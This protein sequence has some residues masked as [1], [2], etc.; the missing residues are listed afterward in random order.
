M[1]SSWAVEPF[2]SR[3][4]KNPVDEFIM[5]LSPGEQ[6]KIIYTIQLLE[7]LGINLRMPHSRAI[8]GEDSL[9]EL[10]SQYGSNI[11]RIFYFHYTGKTFILLHGFTK[12]TQKTPIKEIEIAKSRLKDYLRQKEKR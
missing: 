7:M 2:K 4:G 12:K 6:R 10:R 1:N 3:D 5:S 11:Q 8:E 9:F